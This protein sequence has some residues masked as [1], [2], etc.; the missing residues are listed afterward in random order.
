MITENRE[1]TLLISRTG[2]DK[3]IPAGA[4]YPA[5]IKHKWYCGYAANIFCF[6]LKEK[7]YDLIHLVCIYKWMMY[8]IVA[9]HLWYNVTFIY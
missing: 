4:N 8:Y 7:G 2:D 5:V 3:A 1:L 9:N 6:L